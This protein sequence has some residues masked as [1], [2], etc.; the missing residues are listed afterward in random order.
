MRWIVARS[1]CLHDDITKPY[2]RM[3]EDTVRECLTSEG[4]R[5]IWD[6][7]ERMLVETSPLD[8][9]LSAEKVPELVALLDAGTL[10]IM[11]S[12]QAKRARKL[13]AFVLEDLRLVSQ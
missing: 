13:L 12:S 9:E 10:D 3:A 1:T 8:P 6:R 4:V 7:Y 5:L 11:A 2:W